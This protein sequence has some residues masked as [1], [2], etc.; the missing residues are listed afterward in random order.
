M[1]GPNSEKDVA[2]VVPT[3][4]ALTRS[5][6][7]ATVLVKQCFSEKVAVGGSNSGKAGKDMCPQFLNS[8]PM[9]CN[10]FLP[11]NG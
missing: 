8:F 11:R 6:P 1:V 4:A 2:L 9:E 7:E 5:L 3:H 10:D